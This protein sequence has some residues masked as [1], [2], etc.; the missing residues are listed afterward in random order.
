MASTEM[1]IFQRRT[2]SVDSGE[3]DPTT[4]L[5]TRGRAAS[6]AATIA[7]ASGS[8]SSHSLSL[9]GRVRAVSSPPTFAEAQ[10][11]HAF[12]LPHETFSRWVDDK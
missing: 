4:H 7:L 12:K 10:A 6:E 9:E 8:V 11:Q 3:F 2:S 1:S 5:C